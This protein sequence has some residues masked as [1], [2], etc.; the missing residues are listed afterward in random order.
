MESSLQCCWCTY[1][2]FFV[3]IYLS[4][5]VILH[6]PNQFS[7]YNSDQPKYLI[8]LLLWIIFRWYY[9]KCN[10]MQTSTWSPGQNTEARS[11]PSHHQCG[12]YRS[13]ELRRPLVVIY[14]TC[15]ATE[16]YNFPFFRWLYERKPHILYTFSK[17]PQLIRIIAFWNVV[18]P[19]CPLPSSYRQTI[20]WCFWVCVGIH[21]DLFPRVRL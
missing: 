12:L 1:L 3:Q 7:P 8:S 13:M 4:Y 6:L 2:Y 15:A 14:Y 16:T 20:K 11:V 17:A 18:F 5:I 9:I 21:H 19:L 10:T